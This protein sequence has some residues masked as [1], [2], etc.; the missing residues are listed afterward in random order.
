MTYYILTIILKKD[1]RVNFNFVLNVQISNPNECSVHFILV[2][3]SP[4]YECIIM[5]FLL[6]KMVHKFGGAKLKGLNGWFSIGHK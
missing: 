1:C 3:S 4:S 2:N 6:R 5:V